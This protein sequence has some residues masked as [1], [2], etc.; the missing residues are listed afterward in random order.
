MLR[1]IAMNIIMK[2]LET[3]RRGVVLVKNPLQKRLICISVYI[4][5]CKI[6]YCLCFILFLLDEIEI[7]SLKCKEILFKSLSMG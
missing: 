4:D 3:Q 5:M 6:C 2:I 1:Q 7:G